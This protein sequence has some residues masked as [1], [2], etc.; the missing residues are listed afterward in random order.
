[1]EELGFVSLSS[2]AGVFIKRDGN[3]FVIAIIYVDDAIFCGPDKT[4]VLTMKEA[5]MRKLSQ[6]SPL[7][8]FSSKFKAPKHS[9]KS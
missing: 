8:S 4:F 5:F 3:S 7:H 9:F 6:F 1:M 2:D